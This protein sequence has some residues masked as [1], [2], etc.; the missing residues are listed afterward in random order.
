MSIAMS[1]RYAI[2][3][4][5]FQKHKKNESSKYLNTVGPQPCFKKP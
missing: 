1:V 4:T 2:C 3:Q 5:Y